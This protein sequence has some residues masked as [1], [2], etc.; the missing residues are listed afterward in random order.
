M[1]LALHTQNPEYFKTL[2]PILHRYFLACCWK[3]QHLIPQEDLRKG[4]LGAEKWIEGK[5]DD[6]KLNRLD[7]YAEAVCFAFEHIKTKRG[8]I[9]EKAVSYKITFTNIR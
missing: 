9:F 5:I 4:I 8:T 7:W 6:E 3:I 2:I 1:L